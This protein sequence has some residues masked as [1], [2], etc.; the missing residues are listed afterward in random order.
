VA[1]LVARSSSSSTLWARLNHRRMSGLREDADV[2][3]A[4]AMRLA[5]L[6]DSDKTTAS[7]TSELL[8]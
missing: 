7:L 2:T 3:E 1:L 4:D 8:E 6:I 5:V